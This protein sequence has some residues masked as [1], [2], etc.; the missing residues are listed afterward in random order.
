[1]EWQPISTAPAFESV[2]LYAEKLAF[3][4]SVQMIVGIKSKNPDGDL[5]L[6]RIGEVRPT[7]WMPL[8]DAPNA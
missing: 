2:L 6:S 7:H 8:P 1:M 4:E 3:G 5:W